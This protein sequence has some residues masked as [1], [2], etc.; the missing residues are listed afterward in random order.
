MNI[1]TVIAITAFVAALGLVV[2]PLALTDA[3]AALTTRCDNGDEQCP[4]RSDN[5][6]QGHE[7]ETCNSGG[8]C[9]RGHNKD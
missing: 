3:S 5:P 4:G 2:A 6:G 8:N 7:E 9:P 1:K